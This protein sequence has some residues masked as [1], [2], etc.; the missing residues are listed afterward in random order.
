MY[1]SNSGDWLAL[2]QSMSDGKLDYNARVYTANSNNNNT[3]DNSGTSE[4]LHNDAQYRSNS[5]S[6]VQPTTM[7]QPV[8][9]LSTQA[10]GSTTQDGEGD[11]TLVTPTQAQVEQAKAQVKRKLPWVNKKAAAVSTKRR[12]K[13]SSM[14]GSAG[15]ARK[16][17]KKRMKKLTTKRTKKAKKGQK[18]GSASSKVVKRK[19]KVTKRRR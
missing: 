1:E 8:R 16:N 10:F 7:Q 17:T 12:R 2:Y 13:G 6:E 19:T 18:G 5:T 9:L 15:A 11:L 14:T 4:I 3:N